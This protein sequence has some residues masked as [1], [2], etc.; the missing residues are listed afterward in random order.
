M[1]DRQFLPRPLNW[2]AMRS[3]RHSGNHCLMNW[4]KI[5]TSWHFASTVRMWR[6]SKIPTTSTCEGWLAQCKSRP[7]RNCT[8]ETPHIYS[9]T[10]IYTAGVLIV[11]RGSC[12]YTV[13]IASAPTPARLTTSISGGLLPDHHAPR[14]SPPSTAATAGNRSHQREKMLGSAQPNVGLPHIGGRNELT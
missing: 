14:S 12:R 2:W 11:V 10:R 13:G 3:T 4:R 8:S 9:G 5:N 7:N 1:A 6:C